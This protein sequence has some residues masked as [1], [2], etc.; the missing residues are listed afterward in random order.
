ML[1]GLGEVFHE[2]EGFEDGHGCFIAEK[3]FEFG[4]VFDEFGDDE[5][6]SVRGADEVDFG[7]VGMGEGQS[8]HSAGEEAL[9]DFRR[10][11]VFGFEELDGDPFVGGGV[12][13]H[14]GD[15]HVRHLNFAQDPI[16][17]E[18]F[19]SEQAA[20]GDDFVF[21]FTLFRVEFCVVNQATIADFEGVTVFEFKALDIAVFEADDGVSDGFKTVPSVGVRDDFAMEFRNVPPEEYEVAFE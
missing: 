10:V 21:G 19:F 11:H 16:V 9:N 8:D 7:E 4:L 13:G 5:A 14:V 2:G 18:A 20:I 3:A 17:I 6:V 1:E 12:E 15:V